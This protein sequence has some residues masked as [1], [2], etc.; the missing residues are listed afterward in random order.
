MDFFQ[1]YYTLSLKF[2]T[3]RPRSEKELRDY[4]TKK[5][6]NVSEYDE[7]VSLDELI[8]KIIDQL[9]KQKFL[10][11]LDF[12]QWWVRQRTEFKPRGKR[13]IQFELKQKGIGQDI[14]DS[15]LKETQESLSDLETAKIIVRKKIEK[16]RGLERHEI[17]KKIGGLLG[18]RGYSWT[19]IKRSIDD[20]LGE[21]V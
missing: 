18:R 5:L 1:K 19:D 6:G 3:T 20:V 9:K 12:A 7:S 16:V 11:D 14:I 13:M 15:V 17:Y 4:L 10:S 2:L 21:E 8:Q